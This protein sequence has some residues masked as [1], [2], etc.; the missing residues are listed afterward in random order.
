M[1]SCTTS[2]PK[3]DFNLLKDYYACYFRTIEEPL[4]GLNYL[5]AFKACHPVEYRFFSSVHCKRSKV[6]KSMQYMQ[7]CGLPYFGTLTFKSS[8]DKN[9]KRYKRQEAFKALN[10]LFDAFLVVEELG[11]L[12]GRYHL[13]FVGLFKKDKG[14]ADFIKC[15]HSR[16]NIEKVDSIKEA[17]QYLVKYVVKQLPRVHRNKGLIALEKR[18]KNIKKLEKHWSKGAIESLYPNGYNVFANE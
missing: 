16:Q 6:R 1:K 9:T 5:D 14:F 10:S 4:D 17:S 8:K 15:W 11:E 3:V 7:A 12:K 13:H 18:Y 2:T